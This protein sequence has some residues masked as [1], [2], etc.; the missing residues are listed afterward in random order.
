MKRTIIS[1]IL[2]LSIITS[3]AFGQIPEANKKIVKYVESVIGKKV[4]RGECWDI[5]NEALT[6]IN[7]KWDHKLVYGKL[8][9]PKKDTIYPGD[10]IQFKNVMTEV[11]TEV[12]NGY[13]LKTETMKQHTAIVHKVYS[14]GDFELAHQN[15]EFSGKKVGLSR[16]NIANMKKGKIW[17]YR[18]VTE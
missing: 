3:S 5:A 2:T 10:I 8:L 18:P 11:K 15:T 7:A 13:E 6:L 4:D 9:N 12:K 17:I 14:K 1:I 16:F